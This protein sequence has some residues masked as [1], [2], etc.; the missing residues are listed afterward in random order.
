MIIHRIWF[1]SCIQKQGLT[2]LM[3]T[4]QGFNEMHST[5]FTR[6]FNC[7][8]NILPWRRASGWQ[9]AIIKPTN[10]QESPNAQLTPGQSYTTTLTNR[11]NNFINKTFQEQ[12]QKFYYYF[13]C[14]LCFV[15]DNN[16]FDV[17]V[18]NYRQ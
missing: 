17:I 1:L 16:Y 6:P 5:T 2:F 9:R 8:S 3:R 12:K 15:F 10:T 13:F 7:Q 4:G 18:T 14:L 11:L